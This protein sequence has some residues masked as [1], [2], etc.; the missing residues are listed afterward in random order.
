M[1][2]VCL[3]PLVT[4]VAPQL[5]ALPDVVVDT[6]GQLLVTAGENFRRLHS[7]RSFARL[8]GVAPIPVSS[9]RTGR[10]RLHRGG[11]RDANSACGASRWS[12]C[13][14]TRP[15]GT[16]SPDGPQKAGLKKRSAGGGIAAEQARAGQAGSGNTGDASGTTAAIRSTSAIS[17]AAP[18]E[19]APRNGDWHGSWLA[20]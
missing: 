12:A 13:I 3:T 4:A 15:L 17:I 8:C 2:W 16:T 20:R 11:D 19:L 9:G 6:A 10:H 1:N 7:E 18:M 14:A 5:I